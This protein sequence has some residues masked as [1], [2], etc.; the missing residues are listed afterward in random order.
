MEVLVCKSNQEIMALKTAFKAI[1]EKDL[2]RELEKNVGGGT[3]TKRLFVAIMQA[4]RKD[5]EVTS[6]DV[7]SFP[8]NPFPF[9]TTK[10]ESFLRQ[11]FIKHNG[12][13]LSTS[14][15]YFMK[16]I[17][18]GGKSVQELIKKKFSGQAEELLLLM[19][20]SI[21]NKPRF[22]ACLLED[23]MKGMGT[24]EKELSYW[25]ARCREPSLMGA[26][27]EAYVDLYQK[28]LE[29]RIKGEVSGDYER[30][31]ITIVERGKAVKATAG[32]YNPVAQTLPVL[33]LKNDY[34]SQLEAEKAQLRE[35]AEKARLE[36][37]KARAEAEKVRIEAEVQVRN[38]AKGRALYEESMA[39][40]STST[41]FNGAVLHQDQRI[42]SQ[43]GKFFLI[44]QRE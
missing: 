5:G 38:A 13:L 6:E 12:I 3:D 32:S 10:S 22:Y 21:L 36:A 28:T 29:S 4:A 18:Q 35:E 44:M 9:F 30:L 1:Y 39:R 16:K 8:E 43:N 24:N 2:E 11:L 23:T 34:Q 17:E 42:T 40:L 14:H 20:S 26:I 31:L 25:V 19:C 27:K 7:A 37:D 15:P 33:P 41:L